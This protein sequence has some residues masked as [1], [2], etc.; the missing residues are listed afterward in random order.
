[1][2]AGSAVRI[3]CNRCISLLQT[4]LAELEFGILELVSG[5][6]IFYLLPCALTICIEQ[7]VWFD[8]LDGEAG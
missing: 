2:F 3:A 5:P 6:P 8:L 7:V 4:A 1:M